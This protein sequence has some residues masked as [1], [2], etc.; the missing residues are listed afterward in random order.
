VERGEGAVWYSL[1]LAGQV[2]SIAPTTSMAASADI[3]AAG[4]MVIL[5]Y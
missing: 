5:P 4:N 3:L 1:M 2:G